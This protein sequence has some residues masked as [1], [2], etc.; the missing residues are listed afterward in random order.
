[1]LADPRSKALIENFTGQWPA[2]RD[3]DG[4]AIDARTVL[5]RDKGDEK[6]ICNAS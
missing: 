5:A 1:M 6:G 2:A 4:I 3:V